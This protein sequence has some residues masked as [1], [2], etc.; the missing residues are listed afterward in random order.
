MEIIKK[1]TK[2]V[3]WFRFKKI[4]TK[5][6]YSEFATVEFLLTKK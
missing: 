1:N 2:R 5:H 3:K 4:K 6:K